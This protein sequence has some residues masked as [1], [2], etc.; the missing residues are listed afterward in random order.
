[1]KRYNSHTC[2]SSKTDTAQHF[3]GIRTKLTKWRYRLRTWLMCV[4]WLRWM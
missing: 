2:I 1:M 3:S 4:P